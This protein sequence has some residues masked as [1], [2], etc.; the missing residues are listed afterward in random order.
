MSAY[1]INTERWEICDPMLHFKLLEKQ[2]QAKLKTRRRDTI[3][4]N[5]DT[6]FLSH[7]EERS[8]K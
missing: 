4:I 1:I 7:M 8:K 5:A 6:Y 3:K 2:E